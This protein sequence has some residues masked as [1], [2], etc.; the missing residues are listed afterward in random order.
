MGDRRA[1]D[2]Q[3]PGEGQTAVRLPTDR[4]ASDGDRAERK[5]A[6]RDQT[7]AEP[8]DGDDSDRRPSD[9]QSTGG[10][11]ADRDQP[12]GRLTDG[13]D[14]SARV[15]ADRDPAS[16]SAA[17][18]GPLSFPADD[19]IGDLEVDQRQAEESDWGSIDP[20]SNPRRKGRPVAPHGGRVEIGGGGGGRLSDRLHLATQPDRFKEDVALEE[21]HHHD[22]SEHDPGSSGFGEARA[23]Q[24]IRTEE[25]EGREEHPKTGPEVKIAF[26]DGRGQLGRDPKAE[27]A[28]KE[29]E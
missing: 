12:P 18:K 8:S 29:S 9:A 1:S 16:R 4:C 27:A 10:A 22:P 5:A 19:R 24:Q 23:D 15:V 28:S 3:V 7:D 11:P 25:Y 20:A 17:F 2:R 6:E 13:Q 26:A 14:D 21:H